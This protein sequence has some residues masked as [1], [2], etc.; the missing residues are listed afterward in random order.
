MI[1]M[2]QEEGNPLGEGRGIRI[3]CNVDRGM[4]FL[5]E[6]PDI[7]QTDAASA[8]IFVGSKLLYSELQQRFCLKRDTGVGQF[9]DKPFPI[10]IY[11]QTNLAVCTRCDSDDRVFKEI[12]QQVGYVV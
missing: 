2:I 4:V 7:H 3:F 12:R 10:R 1:P 9:N 6:F 11:L 5:F 8:G